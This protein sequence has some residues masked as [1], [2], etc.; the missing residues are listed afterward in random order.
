MSHLIT[1]WMFVLFL[2]LNALQSKEGRIPGK[3]ERGDSRE[4]E[5]D[6]RV[7]PQAL[8]GPL[9]RT[10]YRLIPRR[11]I[12]TSVRFTLISCHIPAGLLIFCVDLMLEVFPNV[13]RLLNL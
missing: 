8:S 3:K 2:V 12:S 6:Q 10:T 9:L 5:R 13:L 1:N 11:S 7:E 4:R